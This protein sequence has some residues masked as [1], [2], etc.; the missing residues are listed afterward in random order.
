MGRAWAD[1][2]DGPGVAA[3]VMA[4]RTETDRRDARRREVRRRRA[5]GLLLL[6]AV[7]ALLA[8]LGT[9]LARGDDEFS[10]VWW[11]PAS[12]R[13]VEIVRDG[14]EFTFLYGAERRAFTAE[15]RGDDLVIAAP[16]G[17]EIV[18]RAVS[19]DRLELIDGG[20]TTALQP[21][22]DGS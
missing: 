14:D 3:G 6:V 1:A 15:R 2:L 16:L 11:E 19:A 21:A 18:V 4:G 7:T 5:R 20:R 13:R 12:G 10:G 8:I 17:G 22:P 9:S